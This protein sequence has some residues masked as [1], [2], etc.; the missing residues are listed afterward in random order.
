MGELAMAKIGIFFGLFLLKATLLLAAPDLYYRHWSN[1]ACSGNPAV[2]IQYAGSS[3]ASACKCWAQTADQSCQ[4]YVSYKATV[5]I[6]SDSNQD[7]YAIALYSDAGCRNGFLSTKKFYY[8]QGASTTCTQ[9]SSNQKS[10]SWSTT[11]NGM[12]ATALT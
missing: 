10:Y 3:F 7:Y 12:A 8:N 1:N 11:Y 5:Q 4:R 6:S 9:T 2:E